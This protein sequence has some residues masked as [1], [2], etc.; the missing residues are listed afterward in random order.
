MVREVLGPVMTV[1][2]FAACAIALIAGAQTALASDADTART[3]GLPGTWAL[4]CKQPVSPANPHQVFAL[5]AGGTL[6]ATLSLGE[7]YPDQ[8]NAVSDLHLDDPTTLTATWTRASDGYM[9]RA[10]IKKSGAKTRAWTSTNPKTGEALI[11]NAAYVHSGK[12]VPW[13]EK[14]GR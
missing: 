8:R 11:R 1:L 2:R 14:C 13:V 12:P 5:G 7:K 10:T 9:A 6:T 4:D 3:F